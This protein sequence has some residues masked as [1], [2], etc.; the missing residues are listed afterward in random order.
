MIAGRLCPPS[1]AH[2]MAEPEGWG[3]EHTRQGYMLMIG[4]YLNPILRVAGFYAI[5]IALRPLLYL[6]S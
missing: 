2:G 1:S 5:F 3:T 4:L 6:V